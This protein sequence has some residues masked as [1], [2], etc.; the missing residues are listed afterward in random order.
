MINFAHANHYF[1]TAPPNVEFKS[2][3]SELKDV[4]Q[5]FGLGS[6]IRKAKD[7]MKDSSEPVKSN[8]GQPGDSSDSNPSSPPRS[9]SKSKDKDQEKDKDKDKDQEKVKMSVSLAALIVYTVGVKC[10]GFN[11]K[12]HYAVEHV[13]SLSERTANKILKESMGDLVKH[14]RSHVV[15]VYPNGT[16]LSSSNYEPHRYWASGTQL[17]A[18]NWQTFG[19][20]LSFW[21]S[22]IVYSGSSRLCYF[23]LD[24]GYVM[25][26]AMFQRNGKSGYVL[27]PDALRIKDKELKN[28]RTKHFLDITVSPFP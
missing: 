19:A 1:F 3:K 25:N 23:D 4:K 27:K 24:L 18:I 22:Q 11:K 8:K 14:N 26:H 2:F 10:R 6:L 28:K 7:K 12:E 5:E 15:R 20:F 21:F 16:R 9:S 17:V 13:F